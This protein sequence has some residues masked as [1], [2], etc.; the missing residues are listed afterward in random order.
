VSQCERS[1]PRLVRQACPYPPD[2]TRIALDSRH[3]IKLVGKRARGAGEPYAQEAHV[4]DAARVRLMSNPRHPII[5]GL[6]TVAKREGD[7]AGAC[8]R[9]LPPR[10]R[11]RACGRAGAR[12][13]LHPNWLVPSVV[14]HVKGSKGHLPQ[15]KTCD[16]SNAGTG[17]DSRKGRRADR[18]CRNR[19]REAGVAGGVT[20]TQGHG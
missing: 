8:L 16:M 18:Q 12:A 20:T 15:H 17:T 13:A 4:T 7:E 11:I 14:R 1:S 5:I 2:A 9:W 6:P 10:N 3:E 19:G